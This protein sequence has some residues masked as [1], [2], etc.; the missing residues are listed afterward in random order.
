MAKIYPKVIR[1]S[2]RTPRG[3]KSSLG[4]IRMHDWL[5]IQYTLDLS[6]FYKVAPRVRTKFRDELAQGDRNSILILDSEGSGW[7]VALLLWVV[8]VPIHLVSKITDIYSVDAAKRQIE[9]RLVR[10]RVDEQW[11]VD[12]AIVWTGRNLDVLRGVYQI[13]PQAP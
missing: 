2:D 3:G 7:L 13:P 11:H 6:K 10:E 4:A 12:N 5:S 9:E 1:Q 8:D